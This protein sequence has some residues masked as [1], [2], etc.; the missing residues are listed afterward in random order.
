MLKTILIFIGSISLF[1]LG[2]LIGSIIFGQMSD[3][4]GRKRMLLVSH[5]GMFIFDFF[6]AR[7]RSFSEFVVIQVCYYYKRLKSRFRY[8]PAFLPGVT[9]E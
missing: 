3:G 9:P 4:F 5:V 7:S 6:A 1:M 2:C 8:L